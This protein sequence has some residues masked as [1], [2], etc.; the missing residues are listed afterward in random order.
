MS[1]LTA[2]PPRLSRLPGAPAAV[3]AAIPF[4][5]GLALVGACVAASYAASALVPVLSS[6]IWAVFVG[7]AVVTVRPLHERFRPGVRLASRRLLRLG[8][9]LLGLRLG[10]GQLAAIGLPGLAVVLL[11]VPV[12]LGTTRLLG[13]W[14]RVPP[15]LALLV[16]TGSAICGASAIVAMDAGADTTEDDVTVAVATVTLFGTAALVLLPLL[17]GLVLHL[18]P[19]AFGTWVGASVHEVAQV[20]SA[21]TSGGPA[22]VRVATVVKLTRVLMLAPLVL[23]VSLRRGRRSPSRGAAARVPVPLFVAGFLLCVAVVSAGAVPAA[24][25]AVARAVDAGLLTAA[26]VGLGLGVDVRQIAR[27]GWRPMAL[28]FAAWMAAA[29]TA[30][31]ATAL[32]VR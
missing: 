9:A 27:L 30:L 29:G 17:D 24:P 6:L 10:L 12:T 4:L 28:G 11:V 18:S 16:G 32:L 25:L 22:A 19:T 14:L 23:A 8:V 5:P 13:R 26:L 21:A 7:A 20:V 3:P 1:I 15:G 2:S 31:A